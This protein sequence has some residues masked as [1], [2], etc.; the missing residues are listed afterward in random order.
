MLTV[1][2]LTVVGCSKCGALVIRDEEI[3][4]IRHGSIWTVSKALDFAQISYQEE[5]FDDKKKLHYCDVRCEVCQQLVG[6]Y[7]LHKP[8]TSNGFMESQS[9][10]DASTTGG[11]KS[12]F[13]SPTHPVGSKEALLT[14]PCAKILYLRQS[15][16]G[17]IFNK[18]ILLG[19]KHLVEHA[20]DTLLQHSGKH[21][22][23]EGSGS[24]NS[25]QHLALLSP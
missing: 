3:A 19:E 7:Y 22:N 5:K 10:V 2:L 9:F 18:T 4:M 12:A 23:Q 13:S 14:Y 20:I 17:Q 21:N 25:A 16:S 24:I 1:S 6:M 11:N 8:G 15:A